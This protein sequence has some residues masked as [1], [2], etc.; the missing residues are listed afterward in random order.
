MSAAMT[1]LVALLLTAPPAEDFLARFGALGEASTKARIVP[2]LA[3]VEGVQVD[4]ATEGSAAQRLETLTQASSDK[5]FQRVLGPI[6]ASGVLKA[7]PSCTRQ[8]PGF[9][10]SLM[11]STSLPRVF[12]LKEV[13]GKLYLLKVYWAVRGGDD[14]DDDDLPL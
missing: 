2:F 8:P 3:P 14:D 13:G 7:T 4:T 10:C 6:L 1:L 12:E 5:D 9:H 11:T